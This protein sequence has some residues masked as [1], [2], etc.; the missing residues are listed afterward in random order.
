LALGN[1]LLPRPLVLGA[2]RVNRS[3]ER[4]ASGEN[5]TF[6]WTDPFSDFIAEML[7]HPEVMRFWPKCYDRDEAAD[8]VMRQ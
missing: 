1:L 7:A 4:T 8:W 3:L 6:S 2:A 5:M